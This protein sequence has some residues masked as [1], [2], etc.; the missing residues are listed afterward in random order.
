MNR[1]ALIVLLLFALFSLEL[2]C[3]DTGGRSAIEPDGGTETFDPDA[4]PE[5]DGGNEE[6][7]P[8]V[9]SD[10][11]DGMGAVVPIMDPESECESLVALRSDTKLNS[12]CYFVRGELVVSAHIEI[13]P[14][15]E[16]YFSQDSGI[17]VTE[18]GQLGADGTAE[19]PVIF[20]G[21]EN[22]PGYWKGIYYVGSKLLHNNLRHVVIQAAGSGEWLA[23]GGSKGAL[24]L[25]D[26]WTS[27]YDSTIQDNRGVGVLS[28]GSSLTGVTRVR[29]EYNEKPII[30]QSDE[31]SFMEDLEIAN[32]GKDSIFIR[33]NGGINND[34]EWKN[35]GVLNRPGIVGDSYK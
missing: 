7:E 12:R 23:S 32:N 15:V 4:S 28:I 34:V 17:M 29:L 14:G 1:K 33:D 2:A 24:I 11:D 35:F 31:L 13:G 18:E 26:S 20:T 8:D 25:H 9:S 6:F 19:S 3:G 27:V 30:V 21:V 22:R 5:D 10:E 16:F